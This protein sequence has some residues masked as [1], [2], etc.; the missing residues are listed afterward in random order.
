MTGTGLNA[1]AVKSVTTPIALKNM[2]SVPPD[3][4]HAGICTAMPVNSLTE[5]RRSLEVVT[6]PVCAQRERSSWRVSRSLL[7]RFPLFDRPHNR[8]LAHCQL[9]QPYFCHISC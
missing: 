4:T 3:F 2:L 7:Y 5:A 8:Q 9:R 1:T 6:L